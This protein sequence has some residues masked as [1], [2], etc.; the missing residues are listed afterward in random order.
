M[1]KAIAAD[2][3]IAYPAVSAAATRDRRRPCDTCVLIL[4]RV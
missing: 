2:V 4:I 3:L 1:L